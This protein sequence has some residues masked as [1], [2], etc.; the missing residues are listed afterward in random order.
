MLLLALPKLSFAQDPPAWGNCLVS[1]FWVAADYSGSIKGFESYIHDSVKVIADGVLKENQSLRLGYVTFNLTQKL[2]QRP[3]SDSQKIL[4]AI[5]DHRGSQA[6]GGTNIERAL[7]Y[8]SEEQHKIPK[9]QDTEDLEF[10][11][12][13]VLISDGQDSKGS[14]AIN[15][16]KEMKD[17]GW[18]IIPIFL[19]SYKNSQARQ[20]SFNFMQELSGSNYTTEKLIDSVALNE[21]PEYFAKKFSCM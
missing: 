13:L 7:S 8:I 6:T 15:K 4:S 3:T 5:E 10:K 21:L 20:E 19:D 16:A 2:V 12:I 18:W 11:K 1:D 17:D 9:I 14:K